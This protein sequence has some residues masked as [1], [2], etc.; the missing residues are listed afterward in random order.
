MFSLFVS[1]YVN[2]HVYQ[3]MLRVFKYGVNL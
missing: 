1:M 3:K 2:A